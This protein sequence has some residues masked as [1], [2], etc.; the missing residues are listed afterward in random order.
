MHTNPSETLLPFLNNQA[1][2]SRKDQ[3]LFMNTVNGHCQHN[4]LDRNIFEASDYFKPEE[5]YPEFS[6]ENI[7]DVDYSFL[8]DFMCQLKK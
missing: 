2:Q 4:E 5:S 3:T 1:S 8:D 7:L 6:D